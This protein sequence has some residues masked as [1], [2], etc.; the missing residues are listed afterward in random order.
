MAHY[1]AKI[2]HIRP[3]EILDEWG[4][5]ELIVTFGIYANEQSKKKYEEYKQLD[6]KT[7]AS[8]DKPEEYA[9]KFLG[10]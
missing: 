5:P 9:V 8:M 7:R 2:L 3:G 1:V 10:V 6:V 4:V